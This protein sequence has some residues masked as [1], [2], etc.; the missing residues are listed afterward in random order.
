MALNNLSCTLMEQGDYAAARPL[1]E[2]SLALR[3]GLGEKRGIAISVSTVAELALATGDGESATPLLEESLAIVRELG[4]MQFEAIATTE[5]G[6]AGLYA[7]DRK[8]PR[9]LLEQALARC[10]ELDDRQTA[11]DCLSG[12]AALAGLE[13]DLDRAARLFGAAEAVREAVGIVP[14]PTVRPIYDR[15]LPEIA[16]D[17]DEQALAASWQEGKL[18]SPTEAVA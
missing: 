16:A 13:G 12:L 18:Q 2:E 6:L 15:L 14:S 1:A 3:R 5:L 17:A 7:G 9:L 10:L 4:H 8:R 11:A